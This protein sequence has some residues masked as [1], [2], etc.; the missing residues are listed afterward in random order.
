[1]VDVTPEKETKDKHK[2]ACNEHEDGYIER[3]GSVH[4]SWEGIV[5]P[6]NNTHLV[7]QMQVGEAM[8]SILNWELEYSESLGSSELSIVIA[9]IVKTGKAKTNVSLKHNEIKLHIECFVW[10]PLA[11]ELLVNS[12]KVLNPV[13]DE[14]VLWV[15]IISV[16]SAFFIVPNVG[17]TQHSR[18]LHNPVKHLM[19]E[20]SVVREVGHELVRAHRQTPREDSSVVI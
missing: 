10:E 7:I 9:F 11:V 16:D 6:L 19:A 3:C 18:F 20:L 13:F 17:D 2:E 12:N 1:M 5:S 4:E 15:N 8:T 14:V